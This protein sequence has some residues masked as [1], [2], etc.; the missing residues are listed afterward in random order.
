LRR[1]VDIVARAELA[2]ELLLVAAAIDGHRAIALPRR[3][4]H[5]EMPEAAD[6]M[7]GDEIAGA[8]AAVAKSVE[9][10][11]A[12]A[13]QGGRLD[14]VE[15]VRHMR[16]GGDVGDEMRGVAAVAGQAGHLVHVLAGE[17]SVAPAI[18]A[19]AARAA[20]PADAGARPDAPALDALA[21]RVDHADHLVAG[22]ARVRD[23]R[24][25]ALNRQYV[26]VAD[27]AGLHAN[28]YPLG[29]RDRKI[30]LLRHER[31][32]G[33]ADDHRAHLRHVSSLSIEHRRQSGAAFRRTWG[34]VVP[35]APHSP[36]RDGR[37]SRPYA[38]R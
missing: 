37:L 24:R 9:S 13:E 22:N 26:A 21:E 12:G 6:A 30:P 15:R 31:P 7:N 20:E 23:A 3:E 1:A 27:A 19:I 29:A 11:D 34:G 17:S 35:L 14:G 38:G 32:A 10:R 36:S 2:G 8:G 25:Q 33:H 16:D 5:A 28:A 4:L 18:A